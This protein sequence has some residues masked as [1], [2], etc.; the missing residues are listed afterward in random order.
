M[1]KKLR[2]VFEKLVWSSSLKIAQWTLLLD[3][4]G[5]LSIVINDISSTKI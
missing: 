5:Q 3:V 1:D 2:I 4:L